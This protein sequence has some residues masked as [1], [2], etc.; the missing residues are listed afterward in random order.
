MQA[1][2]Q[3]AIDKGLDRD[4]SLGLAFHHA[5]QDMSR[6]D[7]LEPAT[8]LSHLFY[9]PDQVSGFRKIRHETMALAIRTIFGDLSRN[10]LILSET[11]PDRGKDIRRNK[12]WVNHGW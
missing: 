1:D 11:H 5:I 12:E 6:A 4:G 10:G 2:L 8:K 9:T 7:M 3:Q